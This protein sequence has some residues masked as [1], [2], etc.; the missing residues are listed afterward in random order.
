LARKAP[1]VPKKGLGQAKQAKVR[2]FGD[3]RLKPKSKF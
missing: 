2:K 1:K 3:S